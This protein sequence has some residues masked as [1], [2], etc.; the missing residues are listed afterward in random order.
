MRIVVLTS[1]P[2]PVLLPDS[3]LPLELGRQGIPVTAIV[4]RRVSLRHVLRL[5]SDARPSRLAL[6]A[7]A[8]LG[9]RLV[10]ARGEEQRTDAPM[11]IHYVEDHNSAAAVA[12][13]RA[14]SPDLLVLGGTGI[15]G[16][17]V[18][19]IPRLGTLGCHYGL[20]PGLRGV[21]VT[22]WAV[23]LDEPVGVSTFWV[24]GGVDTGDVVLRRRIHVRPGDTLGGLRRRSANVGKELFVESIRRIIDGTAPR[25]PQPSAAGPQCF[26]MHPRLLRLVEQ[27]LREDRYTPSLSPEPSHA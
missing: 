16:R 4:A 11:P 8:A 25:I 13:L 23:L 1:L 17:Q 26:R 19:E 21:N 9:R 5:H 20:L 7:A 10:S 6:N 12:V 22:E 3:F 2:R 27:K 15:I 18:L 24:D 14:L